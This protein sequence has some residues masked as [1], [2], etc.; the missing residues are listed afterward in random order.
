ML[1]I[2]APLAVVGLELLVLRTGL[3]RQG[4]FWLTMAIVLGFQV[5]VD[6][7][8]TKAEGTIVHYDDAVIS[9]I[10]VPWHI[11]IEDFGFGFAMITL[12]LA[13]WRWWQLRAA[14]TAAA[15]PPRTAMPVRDA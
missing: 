6:G 9:G 7:F 5:P 8:L 13:L 3:L 12:T 4:R 1:A 2:A 11:P 15:G 14:A 10:R